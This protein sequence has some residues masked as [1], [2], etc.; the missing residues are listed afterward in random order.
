[1]IVLIEIVE[2]SL[3][4]FVHVVHEVHSLGDSARVGRR[5]AIA[6]VAAFERIPSWV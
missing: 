1:M 5:G 6:C 4:L 2:A 3:P